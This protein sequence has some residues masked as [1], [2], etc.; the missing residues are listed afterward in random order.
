MADLIP[1][2]FTV[3]HLGVYPG[4][5][6]AE[7]ERDGRTRPL[8]TFDT[9]QLIAA[10]W[11]EFEGQPDEPPPKAFYDSAKDSFRMFEPA[12]NE[13]HE[14]PG[15]RYGPNTLY[16]MGHELWTWRRADSRDSSDDG[17]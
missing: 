15:E 12:T 1:S 8:F 4:F 2:K 6:L 7:D 9:A 17:P 3:D 16:A 5:V 11:V 13:W 10:D 14:L